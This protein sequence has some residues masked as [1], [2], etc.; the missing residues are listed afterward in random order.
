MNETLVYTA[1]LPHQSAQHTVLAFCAP[2]KDVLR[3]AI[4]DR[5]G[6]NEDGSLHGF[7]RPQVAN[8]IREI[9]HYLA[10]DD[11][12]LPNSVVVAFT[13]D[14][15]VEIEPL[16]N[17]LARVR[18]PLTDPPLGFVVDGQQRLT[19]LSDLLD[20]PFEVLVSVLICLGSEELRKQFILINN[21]RALPKTLIYELLPTV[22]GLPARLSSRSLAAALVERLNYDEDSSLHGQIKQHTNPTG[23]LQDTAVQKIIMTSLENGAMRNFL[24]DSDDGF[25]RCFQL[26][27]NF[28]RATQQ[29]FPEA[30]FG[31][32]PRTSRLVHSAGIVGMSQVMEYL[33]ATDRAFQAED[34][35]P[36]LRLL[37]DRTAWMSGTWSFDGETMKWNSI[38][39]VPKHYRALSDY[40]VGIIR[41]QRRQAALAPTTASV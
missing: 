23:M 21:T 2:A 4:I 33:H 1:L 5:I 41:R 10:S 3:F 19:A 22:E 7:Q 40:L 39:F 27:S 35:I 36:S 6:R 38:Q 8:H 15:G 29:V 25:D 16:S 37:E 24:S 9:R 12:I 17:G 32:N 13:K 31:Q 34:F 14:A 11:A 18:I 28:F 26:I 20:K 30:W